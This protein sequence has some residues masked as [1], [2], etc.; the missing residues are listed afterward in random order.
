MPLRYK[1]ILSYARESINYIYDIPINCK[2][3]INLPQANDIIKNTSK[4]VLHN[5][6]TAGPYSPAVCMLC[7]YKLSCHLTRTLTALA[8][9]NP[10]GMYFAHA[11]CDLLQIGCR[12]FGEL[13]H[14]NLFTV[15]YVD[16]LC[17]VLNLAT[18]QIVDSGFHFSVFRF[19]LINTCLHLS[20]RDTVQVT[21]VCSIT[22]RV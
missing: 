20:C 15:N 12:G 13:L 9:R 17:R 11:T 14:Q 8:F 7:H 10:H 4:T 22:G 16:T 18:L 5:I 3:V 2:W 1:N 21:V 6:Q 19:S